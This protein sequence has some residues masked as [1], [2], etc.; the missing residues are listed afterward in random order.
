MCEIDCV[1]FQIIQMF[2]MLKICVL[3]GCMYVEKNRPFRNVLSS[4]IKSVHKKWHQFVERNAKKKNLS[5]HWK[6]VTVI[7][8]LN[9]WLSVC[10]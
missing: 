4:N 5:K 1:Y 8:C 2:T 7:L 3:L 9:T 10:G 6:L